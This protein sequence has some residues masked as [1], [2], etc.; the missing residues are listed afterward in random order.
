MAPIWRSPRQGVP[1]G[2]L[3]PEMGG[4]KLSG[5][6]SFAASSTCSRPESAGFRP[7]NHVS[8]T[9]VNASNQLKP[10]Q[11]GTF[12]MAPAHSGCLKALAYVAYTAGDDAVNGLRSMKTKCSSRPLPTRLTS[13]SC[14]LTA[15]ARLFQPEAPWGLEAWGTHQAGVGMRAEP[16]PAPDS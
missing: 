16:P 7:S 11:L 14:L 9:S 12:T 1:A 5:W 2:G 13:A 15:K 3:G 8:Y 10:R 4:F 6:L